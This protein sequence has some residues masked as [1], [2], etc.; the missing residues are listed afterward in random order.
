MAEF[1]HGGFFGHQR[2]Q[3]DDGIDD[4]IDAA[5]RQILIGLGIG[6]VFDDLAELSAFLLQHAVEFGKPGKQRAA[7]LNADDLSVEILDR[8]NRLVVLAF[9]VIV[10]RI[11][12]RAGEIKRLLAFL[13][14]DRG[15]DGHIIFA[16]RDAG[17]DAGPGQDFLLELEWREF[18]Q[19]FDQL[20]V[21]TCGLAVLD[22]FEGTEIVLGRNDEA[23]LLDFI[24]ARG[25]G[26]SDQHWHGE[27]RRQ[28]AEHQAS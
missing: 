2:L 3:I 12:N 10:R 15:G 14:D 24:H 27:Q 8:G 17:Q 1:K 5:E 6:G 21:K 28:R 23:A 26:V 4:I 20:I 7:G 16:G 19:I 11:R 22:E 25:L 13:G 18:A 9:D